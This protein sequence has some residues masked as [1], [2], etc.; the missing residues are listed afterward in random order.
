MANREKVGTKAGKNIYA[1]KWEV[2]N[3][4]IQLYHNTPVAEYKEK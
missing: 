1:K 4:I 3:R 2:E